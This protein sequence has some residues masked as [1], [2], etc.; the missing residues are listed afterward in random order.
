MIN[1]DNVQGLVV[2]L[3]GIAVVVCGVMIAGRANKADLPTSAK[4]AGN[5]FIGIVVGA[6]GVGIVAM[7]AFGQRFLEWLGVS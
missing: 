4:T 1:L 5:A 7:M 6:M 3:L 2:G